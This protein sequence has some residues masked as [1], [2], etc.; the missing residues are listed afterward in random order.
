MNKFSIVC[1]IYNSERFLNECI[2]SV[3]SQSYGNWELILVDDGSTDS[4]PQICDD[5]AK[6]NNQIVVIHEGN[7][8][9][10][11][12][13]LSGVNKATGSHIIFLDSDDT[14]E[15]DALF[16]LDKKLNETSNIDLLFFN[17]KTFGDPASQKNLFLFSE[18]RL[19]EGLENYIIFDELYAKRVFGYSCFCCFRKGI[20]DNKDIYSNLD[21]ECR[22]TED[23]IFLYNCVNSSK[24]FRLII[25]VLYNYRMVESS[26]SHNIQFKDK[27]HR[28]S[29]YS[30]VYS[31]L[32]NAHQYISF[33]TKIAETLLWSAVSYL[34][35]S[36]NASFKDEFKFVKS[37][38][39][40]KQRKYFKIKSKYLK[41]LRFF[42]SHN[43]KFMTKVLLKG[44]Q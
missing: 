5:H 26:A 28:F 40:I 38:V 15:K 33:E 21:K 41:L 22:Y 3:L 30:K 4:S 16:I 10:L 44:H 35:A 29:N 42:I 13:R 27:K 17:A 39:F 36:P 34:S 1:P 9:Q 32:I 19:I 2:E 18:D 11:M 12:A 37:S 20:F 8:G 31:E 14:L 43:F 23:F 6:R 7:N 24:V 25:D